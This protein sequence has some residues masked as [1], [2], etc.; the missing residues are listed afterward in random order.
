MQKL[1]TTSG[2]AVVQADL[3]LVSE[4]CTGIYMKTTKTAPVTSQPTYRKFYDFG[5]YL[6]HLIGPPARRAAAPIVP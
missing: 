3:D 2:M 6:Y 4:T 1:K 5:I